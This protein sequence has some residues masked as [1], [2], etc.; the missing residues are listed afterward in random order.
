MDLRP[1]SRP[2]E[3]ERSC[4]WKASDPIRPFAEAGVVGFVESP[5]CSRRRQVRAAGTASRRRVL[6]QRSP[7]EHIALE[8]VRM[9][10]SRARRGEDRASGPR[11]DRQGHRDPAVRI[12]PR[13]PHH[14][15]S[16]AA[17]SDSRKSASGSIAGQAP[18]S[19][20]AVQA[21][22]P[23]KMVIPADPPRAPGKWTTFRVSSGLP[24]FSPLAFHRLKPVRDR[25][26]APLPGWVT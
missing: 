18:M 13:A 3:P 1:R 22:P 21:S 2:A 11:M 14:S 12:A 4:W 25:D 7:G 10:A 20:K 9:R 8:R 16:R 26:T 19:D 23:V 6:P 24:P 17:P 15:P 5:A